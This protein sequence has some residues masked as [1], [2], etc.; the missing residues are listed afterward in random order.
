MSKPAYTYKLPSLKENEQMAA[1]ILNS[2]QVRES[3]AEFEC[4]LSLAYLLSF[5]P[6][7]QQLT[8]YSPENTFYLLI[9]CP[10]LDGFPREQAG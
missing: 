9:Y 2:A 1:E 7:N 3:T 8:A 4:R 5:P 6:V 10:F